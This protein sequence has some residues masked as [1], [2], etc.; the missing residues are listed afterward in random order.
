MSERLVQAIK[1]VL[2]KEGESGKGRLA[3]VIGR[4]TRMIE[5]YI[6]GDAVPTQHN[7]FRLAVACGL[8]EEDAAAIA[9]ECASWKGQ[10]TA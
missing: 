8:G 1:T 10:R 4:R 3:D 5:R 6:D 7:A 2:L 9:R